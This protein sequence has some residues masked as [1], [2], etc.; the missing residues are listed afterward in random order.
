MS[1][2]LDSLLVE[3]SATVRDTI[4]A[5]D[6]NQTGI[7]LVVDTEGRLVA[8]VTDGDIRRAMLAD[9]DID[10]PVSTLLEAQRARGGKEPIVAAST[11][12]A[13]ELLATMERESVRHVPLLDGERRVVGV[14]LLDELVKTEAAPLRA[15]V[16]AGGFGTRLGDLTAATPKPMLPVGGRPLLERIIAQ[17]REAGI[18]RVNLTTHYRAESIA[19]HFGDGTAFGVDI[20]YVNEDTPLGT[21]GSLATVEHGDEPILVMNGD[22]VTRVDFAA[23]QRFHTEHEAE[24]TVALRPYE[25]SV[26]YGIVDV[27]GELVRDVTEKPLV[28]AFVN[29]GIYL[30]EPDVCRLVPSGERYDMTDLIRTLVADGRR[31]IGF[32]LREYWL[33]IG[34]LEDYAQAVQSADDR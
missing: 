14:A 13:A 5:I 8:T 29:A 27:D 21:A 31:V 34:T 32:P 10:A 15:V 24:L 3:P 28:R 30:L 7:A 23:M 17:L 26:P 16:M 11:T 1:R 20:R 9:L 22:L 25:V 18:R 4:A 12:P 6:R 19:G 33:D 2:P